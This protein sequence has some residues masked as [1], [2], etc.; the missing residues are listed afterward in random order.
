MSRIIFR[1]APLFLLVA[2]AQA[3]DPTAIWNSLAQPVFDPA[4]TATV[5]NV[6]IARDRIKIA[7]AE[8]Q[9]Q[10]S[11]AVNGRVYG[12]A[13]RGRGRVE[14]VPPSPLEARQLQTISGQKTLDMEFSD[15]TF[16]FSDGTFEELSRVLK[17][18][19]SHED[20]AGIYANRQGD[21]ESLGDAILPRLFKGLLSTDAKR[22][23][24]F[25][26][27]LK[28]KDKGWVEV[29]YDAQDIEEV[30][31]GR[32]T[33][34][35]THRGYDAWL[36]FPAGNRNPMEV[37]RVPTAKDDFVI[38]GFKIDATVTGSAELSAVTRVN[39]EARE[40]GERVYVFSLDSNLRVSSVKTAQGAALSF[41]QAK[42]RKDGNQS[43]G[44]YVAV[45]LPEA[46]TAGQ[47][48]D[49]EFSYAGKRVVRKVGNGNYFCQSEG[50]YPGL[51][52][53]FV[54]RYDFE[55]AFR[56]PKRDT[57]VATGSKISESIEGDHVVSV[58]KS[59][60]PMAVAGF[61]FGDFK[62]Y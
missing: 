29:S 14:V 45:A 31:I 48:L 51:G 22:T 6:V 40:P 8:G 47:K 41:F 13:F 11:Q 17:W 52:D 34:W 2:A 56:S 42:E 61:A 50:W 3:Q 35:V 9:I 46:T 16:S 30:K 53:S 43:T 4:K 37:N 62:V 58:W 26:A 60:I 36:H 15:A 18:S 12:A 27:D 33:S 1:L 23:A 57:L 55:M 32:W 20:L 54:N 21:R 5:N 28:T 7:L 25:F 10:F 24:L 39:M 59:D 49:L 19:T 44:N 38:H